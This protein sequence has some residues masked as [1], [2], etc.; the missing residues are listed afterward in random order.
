VFI[1]RKNLRSFCMPKI[2]VILF[3]IYFLLMNLS[4]ANAGEIKSAHW[5]LKSP[6]TPLKIQTNY[7]Q[8]L[9]SGTFLFYVGYEFQQNWVAPI[10]QYTGNLHRIGVLRLAYYLAKTVRLQLSG[11][12]HQVLDY[13]KTPDNS[14]LSD[15][16]HCAADVGDFSIA[17]IAQ[18]VS[19][20]KYWPAL[21]LRIDTKLPNTN[22]SK[23]IGTN[24]TDI[25]ITLLSTYRYGTWSIFSDIGV[26]ILS[27]PLKVNLQNDVLVYG[28]GFFWQLSHRLQLAGEV[29][30]YHSTINKIPIGTEDRGKIRLGVVWKFPMFAVEVYPSYGLTRYEGNWGISAGISLMGSLLNH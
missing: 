21:G 13:E 7:L 3:H 23:G 14:E 15:N 6:R 27:A 5:F 25:T 29:N 30:G 4:I 10:Y 28:A 20:T 8:T 16:S 24:T 1:Q 22:Q 18:L 26:G 19:G 2:V 12:I 17:T 9:P 11:G